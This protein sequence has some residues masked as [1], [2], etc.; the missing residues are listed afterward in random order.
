MRNYTILVSEETLSTGV[1]ELSAP[2]KDLSTPPRDLSTPPIISD[3]L[4]KRIGELKKREHDTK[5]VE[6]IILEICKN[7]P[8]KASHVAEILNKGED[9]I[10]RKYLSPMIKSMK[11]VYLYPDMVNHPNQAYIAQKDV[12]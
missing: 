3:A 1:T 2:P 4:K 6:A 5:K 10:K 11:L 7:R 9:Y 8:V 12:E